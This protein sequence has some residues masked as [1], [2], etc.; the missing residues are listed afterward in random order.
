MKKVAI[1]LTFIASP[2]LALPFIIHEVHHRQPYAY[3]LFSLFLA[4]VAFLYPPTH[5]LWRHNMMYYSYVQHP[6]DSLFVTQNG[7]D[8]V[9]YSLTALFAK[10]NIPFEYV[11]FLLVFFSYVIYFK[12]FKEVAA[13]NTILRGSSTNYVN[14][15]WLMF[16][17][18]PFFDIC[19]GLRQGFAVALYTYGVY[20]FYLKGKT[21]L[22]CVFLLLSVFT[23]FSMISVLPLVFLVKFKPF[24]INIKLA[25]VL[26]VVAYA[27]SLALF[28]YLN[29]SV[30]AVGEQSTYT[31]GSQ[32]V[33]S[34]YVASRSIRSHITHAIYYC[35]AIPLIVFTLK[36]R[37][38]ESKMYYLANW[39]LVLCGLML[40]YYTVTTRY[41]LI[42]MT[43]SI[44][45]FIANC[46]STKT[47]LF[48]LEFLFVF[49]TFGI[50]AFHERHTILNLSKEYYIAAPVPVILVQEYDKTWLF[51]TQND[52]INW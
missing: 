3:V 51:T 27:I 15:F 19:C 22:G 8:Y 14:C 4:L 24:Q 37:I 7:L 6:A 1:I 11:R 29:D 35:M 39:L 10:C 48:R 16:F 36:G 49:L 13:Q 17:F 31:T 42:F 26:A 38:P 5:D 9:L 47:L 33:G 44:P 34:D 46:T 18:I 12:V 20:L 21:C 2:L 41:V 43:I 28:G 52:W 45:M 50:R 30:E 32:G 23:H 25:L 40:P